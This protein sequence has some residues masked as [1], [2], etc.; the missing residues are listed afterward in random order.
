MTLVSVK[1]TSVT[2]ACVLA[3]N[4]KQTRHNI[5]FLSITCWGLFGIDIELVKYVRLFYSDSQVFKGSQQVRIQNIRS[6]Y[7]C[8]VDTQFQSYSNYNFLATTNQIKSMNLMKTATIIKHAEYI[9]T[10]GAYLRYRSGGSE[11]YYEQY[12]GRK[13]KTGAVLLI[14]PR[15][16]RIGRDT[17]ADSHTGPS[18]NFA[19]KLRKRST[20]IFKIDTT[21]ML[22]SSSIENRN[23]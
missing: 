15:L 3:C 13:M 9:L 8:V 19:L 6:D 7:S 23:F 18:G 11:D 16:S 5:V 20:Y 21:T 12:V 1:E 22:D 4:L 17:V 10:G 14:I 2:E